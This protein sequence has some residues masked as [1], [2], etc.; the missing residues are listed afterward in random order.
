M[1]YPKKYDPDDDL[2]GDVKKLIQQIARRFR[3]PGLDIHDVQDYVH[4]RCFHEALDGAD[5]DVSQAA[6]NLG[7]RYITMYMHVKRKKER[8]MKDWNVGEA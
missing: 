8:L 6:K 4:R 7:V 1:K 3:S 5:Q 2:P